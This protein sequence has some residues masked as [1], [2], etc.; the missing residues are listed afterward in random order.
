MDLLA[1]SHTSQCQHY[2]TLENLLPLGALQLN[3]FNP[4]WI[5]LIINVSH[6]AVAA[7][8]LLMLWSSQTYNSD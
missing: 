3:V 2:Y 5:H 8:A 1:Y 6:P 4:S 7:L